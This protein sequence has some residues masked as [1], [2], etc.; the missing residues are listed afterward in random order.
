[1]QGGGSICIGC[2]IQWNSCGWLI[3]SHTHRHYFGLLFGKLSFRE[4]SVWYFGP[5]HYLLATI[6]NRNYAIQSD[7]FCALYAFDSK[8]SDRSDCLIQIYVL[9]CHQSLSKKTVQIVRNHWHLHNTKHTGP[10]ANV[11]FSSAG[12]EY[13]LNLLIFSYSF[14]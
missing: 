3:S 8:S 2:V 10:L 7:M 11:Y 1:M 6:V 9:F 4:N 14:I 13:T 5:Q 12:G